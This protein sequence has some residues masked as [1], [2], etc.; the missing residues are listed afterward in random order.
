MNEIKFKTN[1]KIDFSLENEKKATSLIQGEGKN[2]LLV[3]IPWDNKKRITLNNDIDI[4]CI[5]YYENQAYSFKTKVLD[6]IVENIPLYKIKKPTEVKRIQRRNYV[7]IEHNQEIF[8]SQN[9]EYINLDYND[10]NNYMLNDKNKNEFIRAYS[11]DI[12]GGGMKVSTV[13][14]LNRDKNIVVGFKNS[15]IQIAIKGEICRTKKLIRNEKVIY[16]TGIKFI[17]I[18]E[19]IREKVIQFIFVKMR[20]KRK[21]KLI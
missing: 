2:Y 5:Y 10:L 20:E 18:P 6:K 9:D 13:D 3:T 15:N 1:S 8:Y 7:R 4:E 11:V 19:R 16:H 12:S 17:N 14:K 21:N